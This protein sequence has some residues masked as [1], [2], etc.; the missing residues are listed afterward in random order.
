MMG[1][2]IVLSVC[3]AR[4][5]GPE[6]CLVTPPP[7]PDTSTDHRPPWHPAGWAVVAVAFLVGFANFPLR[8]LGTNFDHLPGDAV[9]NRL[10]NY[11]LEH[12]YRYL[13]GHE[14]SFW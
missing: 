8:A 14:A 7:E 11:V 1:D 4:C 9:D 5:P 12:G 3:S 6:T 13:T 2:F 10:N